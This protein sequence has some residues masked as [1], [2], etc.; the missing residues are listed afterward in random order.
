MSYKKL[1]LI[2]I[3]TGAFLVSAQA[4]KPTL[5]PGKDPVEV[6]QVN[7]SKGDLRNIKIKRQREGA[8]QSQEAEVHVIKLHVQMPPPRG[9]AY[10]LYVG[11]TKINAYGGFA[12][13]IY[14][15]TYDRKDLAGLRGKPVRFM[16]RSEAID[17][18][19]SVPAQGNQQ[20]PARLP[21][22]EEVLK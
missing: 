6:V 2:A 7:P 1:F 21:E 10:V 4:D 20:K 3:L 16:Y 5:R 22:L 19:V 17:L 12:E 14:F 11:D 15:K 9:E 8:D 13:G 18:G